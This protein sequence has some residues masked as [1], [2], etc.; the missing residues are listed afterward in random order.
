MTFEK[1]QRE[2]K[3]RLKAEQKRAEREA[4]KAEKLT[5]PKKDD[6]EDADAALDQNE[7]A[8]RE[9]NLERSQNE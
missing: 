1:T 5:A 4:R 8:R 6:M 2:H 9:E 3:K 7:R